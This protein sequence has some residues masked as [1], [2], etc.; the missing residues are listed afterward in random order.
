MPRAKNTK[1]HNIFLIDRNKLF[2]A[3]E[4]N[5]PAFD[6]VN[7]STEMAIKF[8]MEA[9]NRYQ[10]QTLKAGVDM[11]GFSVL[12]FFRGDDNYQSKFSAFCKA[13][14]EDGQPAVTFYP[15]SASSVLFIWN[16]K[17]IYAITTGQGFRMIEDYS[18]PKFGLIIASIFEERFKVTSLDSN[19]ISSIVHS[20][21]T[22]YSNEIDFIDLDALDTV[23]KEVTGRLKDADK[24]HSLLN[25][26]ADSKR[27]S[28]KI[29][30]KNY[31]Q[32]SNALSFEGLLHLLTIIDEYDFE[33]LNDRFNL[34]TPMKILF[35]V[36]APIQKM[37][38]SL[39]LSQM[40]PLKERLIGHWS[41]PKTTMLLSLMKSTVQISL[42]Y[43]VS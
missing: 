40:G 25:L 13:F 37:G 33:N 14:V 24:V 19:T 8:L 1:T 30:A 3:I 22:V 43:L 23:F 42:K 26:S 17:S 16:E 35:R 38:P 9:D 41:I 20:T 18:I 32:F 29:T 2:N 11:K 36:S 12:L 6:M 21:K 34:I 28:M 39:L 4:G 27:R 7:V 15:R 10:M 5:H 31:V